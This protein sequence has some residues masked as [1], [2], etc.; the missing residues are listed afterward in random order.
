MGKGMFDIYFK[1]THVREGER[2]GLLL[3]HEVVEAGGSAAQLT[4]SIKKIISRIGI[5]Y[6]KGKY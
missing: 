1:V 6:N 2:G 5:F 4:I 3:G